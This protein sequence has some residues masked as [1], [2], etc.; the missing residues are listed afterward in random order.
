MKILAIADRPARLSIKEI[1]KTNNIDMI[2][3]LGD[4]DLD[5]IRE[6]EDIQSIPKLG[7]YGNHDSGTY[8]E[9]LGIQNMHLK[10]FEFKGFVFGG[11]E[12]CVRYKESSAP[13]FTQEEAMVLMKDCSYVDVFLAH[14]PPF[15]INDDQSET[16]HTGFIALKNYL[17]QKQPKYFLHGHTYPSGEKL[18]TEYA[19]TKIIYVY[20]DQIIE[21]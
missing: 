9:P 12:G 6:L 19:G 4:L 13:M 11:F 10:T 15:G 20:Q 16:A 1:V 14:C 17:D 18:V 8:M 2:I 3:T 5:Q 21:L 7:V